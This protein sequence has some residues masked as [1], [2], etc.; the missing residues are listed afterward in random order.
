[1]D[2]GA[3]AVARCDRRGAETLTGK[4]VSVADGDTITILVA[5]SA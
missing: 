4:V 1:V 2:R 5:A 3:P